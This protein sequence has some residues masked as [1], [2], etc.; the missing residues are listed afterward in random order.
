MK[1]SHEDIFIY[2]D[3]TKD[4]LKKKDIIKAIKFFIS[5]NNKT[6]INGHYALLIF[7]NE[8]NPVFITGKKDSDIIL[9]A[10]EENWKSRPKE[11][12]YFENGLF[13]I[14]SYIAETVRKK[15]KTYRVIVITDTPS[16]LSDDYTDALFNLVSKI[17]IFPTFIDIIRLSQEDKRF[18]KDDVKLNILASDT[19]GSIFYVKDKVQFKDIVKQL[20]NEIR[21]PLSESP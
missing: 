6:N 18:F 19:E 3:L 5:E 1:A 12:S 2:L 15:S 13:Y 11:K 9:N 20:I 17:K 10:I 14:F 16:D 4:L 21:T 8:G 7:Q